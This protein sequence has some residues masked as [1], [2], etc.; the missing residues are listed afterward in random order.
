MSWRDFHRMT[1]NGRRLSE[2]AL[3]SEAETVLGQADGEPWKRSVYAF[4]V[5]WFSPSPYIEAKTSGST[6]AP[7]IVKLEK[8]AMCA[9]AAM[10][11][12]Y[13]G[14]RSGDTILLCLSADYIA[15]KMMLVRALVA[16]LDVLLV[17]P[18]SNPLKENFT[19]AVTFSAFVPMQLEAG[20]IA[21][22]PDV[23]A[24]YARRLSSIDTVIVGGSPM[25]PELCDVLSRLDCNVYATYGMT[26]TYSHIAVKRID[27][28]H[29]RRFFE[30]LP[31]IHVSKDARDCLVVHA[32][33]LG[34]DRVVT[35]DL[36]EIEDGARFSVL[37]RID[38]VINTGSVKVFPERIER[39]IS[40][41]FD[42]R[43][44]FVFPQPD[45]E[46]YQ[47]VGLLIEGGPFAEAKT[48]KLRQSMATYVE[49]YERPKDIF[50]LRNFFETASGKLDRDATIHR[51]REMTE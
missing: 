32:P 47:R 15:G 24:T 38:H 21:A 20:L 5:E 34:L 48:Q 10:T 9:S 13:F 45:H 18:S 12:D 17:P 41:L 40:P 31:G 30:S 49:P 7:K 42:G 25:R 14:L 8:D 3:L 33:R 46:L 50:F 43:R 1:L 23:R 29:R 16:D 44:F 37:G 26:E 36:V 6:G 19:H 28:E 2:R 39:K 4:I 35:N 51:L 22:G 27:R 11:C